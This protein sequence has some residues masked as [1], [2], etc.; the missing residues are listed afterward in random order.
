MTTLLSK[1]RLIDLIQKEGDLS[2]LRLVDKLL[3][4]IGDEGSYRAM[5]AEGAERSE[6][7]IKAGRVYSKEEPK[8]VAKAGLKGNRR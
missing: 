4:R 1:P 5:L 2:L 3:A 6:A 8:A 7:D